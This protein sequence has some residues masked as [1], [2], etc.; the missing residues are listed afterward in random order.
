[1]PAVGE[2]FEGLFA[3]TFRGER[4]L[5]TRAQTRDR[6]SQVVGDVVEGAPHASDER[7]DPREHRVEDATEL[8]DHVAMW[9]RRDPRR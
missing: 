9:F 5:G 2:G 8:V 1:V 6:R 7:L 3:R 4:G